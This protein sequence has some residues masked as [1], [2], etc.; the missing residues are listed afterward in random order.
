MKMN[1]FLGLIILFFALAVHA[2]EYASLKKDQV[3]LR[4]GPGDRYPIM[5]VYQ[6]KNYPVEVLES[7]EHWRQIRE[8]DG[9]IG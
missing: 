1:K 2:T 6:E 8:V 5:W 9:T 7:F 3:N 4:T